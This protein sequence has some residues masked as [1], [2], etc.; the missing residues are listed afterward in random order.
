MPPS[1]HLPPLP[2]R[3]SDSH[4]GDYGR[5]LVVAGSRGMTGAACLAA[6][7][8]LRS[9]AGIVTLGIPESQ[10][11]VAASHLVSAMTLPLPETPRGTLSAEAATEILAAAGDFTVLA[12]GPGLSVHAET[13]ACVRRVLRQAELPVVVDA[14][15]LNALAGHGSI[16]RE[17]SRPTVLTPHPGEYRRLDPDA[18]RDP[19]GQEARVRRF[20][21]AHRAVVAL[22]THETIVSDGER[23]HRNETGNPGMATGGSGDVLTGVVAG[24]LAGGQLDPFV[25]TCLAVHVHGMAGDR[26]RDR[27][28]EI[29][30]TAEDILDSLASA[31]VDYQRRGPGGRAA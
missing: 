15:G 10:Q 5:V 31:F 27:L 22:K 23:L 13:V 4:K 2:P 25:A 18:P 28:G 1:P 8:A 3:R 17:R 19:A 29:S 12:I 11:P 6:M 7:A 24:L 14:D 21:A 9:G 30:M 20:A 26:A 16:L